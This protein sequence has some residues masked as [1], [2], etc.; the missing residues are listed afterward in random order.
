MVL[1]FIQ[2]LRSQGRYPSLPV[3]SSRWPPDYARYPVTKSYNSLFGNGSIA[4]LS[5]QI[6]AEPLREGR[7]PIG[8]PGLG[9]N[10]AALPQF[11]KRQ[12]GIDRSPGI[13]EF[14]QITVGQYLPVP[15]VTRRDLLDVAPDYRR[16]VMR[17]GIV[18]AGSPGQTIDFGQVIEQQ[19]PREFRLDRS[20]LKSPT[21]GIDSRRRVT[22]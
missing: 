10:L 22:A 21:A 6:D 12:T 19:R 20:I 7:V 8:G 15:G 9:G 3:R 1:V 16:T 17:Q 13:S 4:Y 11:G 5:G 14:V 18:P 2:A